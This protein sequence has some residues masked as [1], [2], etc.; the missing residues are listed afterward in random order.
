VLSAVKAS[1]DAPMSETVTESVTLT[2][3]TAHALSQTEGNDPDP[4]AKLSKALADNPSATSAELA[5]VV[6][7]SANWVRSK[8]SE[9]LAA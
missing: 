2:E 4:M 6:G 1:S 3:V 5:P 8:R 9:I 7:R